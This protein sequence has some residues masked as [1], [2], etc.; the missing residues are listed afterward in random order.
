MYLYSVDPTNI[1][2]HLST[3]QVEYFILFGIAVAGKS[4]K[5]TH[6]KL[7][8]F[9]IEATKIFSY[10]PTP[11]EI[12]R[13]LIS[14]G[15]LTG[16]LTMARFGQ[17]KRIEAA[18]EGI[19]SLDVEGLSVEALEAIPGIGPK[20]ARFIMLYTDP[21]FDGVP[22]DTHILKFLKARFGDVLQVP[23][24][25]PPAGP[26]YKALER[27]FRREALIRGKT[28]RELDT[29]VWNKYSSKS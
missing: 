23:K 13:F 20:T 4:A 6:K 19:A 22:L 26:R 25:T 12:L 15:R 3:P 29:E 18:F 27:L 7:D 8:K 5:Q 9:L 21:S 16:A 11:F 24:N 2:A 14:T 1:P 28:V 17:Y 10:V